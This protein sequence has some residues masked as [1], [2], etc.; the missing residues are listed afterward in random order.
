MSEWNDS[1]GGL[2]PLLQHETELVVIDADTPPPEIEDSGEGANT[3]TTSELTGRPVALLWTSHE[4]EDDWTGL[5]VGVVD[6][7][8]I[9]DLVS[10]DS[11]Y[12]AMGRADLV[13]PLIRLNEEFLH[14]KRYSAARAH[15]VGDEGVRRLKDRYAVGVGVQLALL[16]EMARRQV[17][18]AEAVSDEV[19][20]EMRVIAARGVLA[21]MPAFDQLAQE[22]GLEG[23]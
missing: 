7:A 2:G 15:L 10:V 22:A 14:L 1:R 16:E 23:Y 5:T 4:R 21:I 20:A 11:E 9:S 13:V 19:L 18:A 8:R 6:E 17:E 3:S 12:A